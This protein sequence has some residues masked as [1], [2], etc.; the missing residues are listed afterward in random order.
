MTERTRGIVSQT[1][2]SKYSFYI[3]LEGDARYYNTKYEPKCGQGDDV[4]IEFESKGPDRANISKV[5]I[6][7]KGARK[8]ES[9][10]NYKSSGGSEDKKQDS[11]VWQH[12]QQMAIRA[13]AV[14]LQSNA[15]KLQKSGEANAVLIGNLIDELTYKFFKDGID[16]RR[17]SV[18]LSN[19]EVDAD[20][21]PEKK[22]DDW[23]DPEPESWGE[24]E[25]S[26]S[27]DVQW[28]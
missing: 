21:E 23:G 11:I 4:G 13:A 19:A 25:D 14:L 9:S 10:G 18:Y 1:G 6:L 24:E 3:R 7:K 12:S 22:S 28:S 2:K 17:S 20:V 26:E 5:T 8:A 16:P 15:V 27:E